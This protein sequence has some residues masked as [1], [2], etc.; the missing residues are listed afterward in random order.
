MDFIFTEGL[1][2]RSITKLALENEDDEDLEHTMDS[3][4]TPRLPEMPNVLHRELSRSMTNIGVRKFVID[5]PKDQELK[6]RERLWQFHRRNRGAMVRLKGLNPVLSKSTDKLDG[7]DTERKSDSDN[8]EEKSPREGKKVHKIRARLKMESRNSSGGHS[9]SVKKDSKESNKDNNAKYT[10]SSALT[11][12]NSIYSQLRG[13]E[14]ETMENIQRFPGPIECGKTKRSIVNSIDKLPDLSSALTK[15]GYMKLTRNVVHYGGGF[16]GRYQ[17]KRYSELGRSMSSIEGG[18]RPDTM[19]H[20]VA[21]YGSMNHL[22]TMVETSRVK[23]ETPRTLNKLDRGN[24]ENQVRKS[25][26]SRKLEDRR[27]KSK[28]SDS[29]KKP[30]SEQHGS[31]KATNSTVES[32]NNVTDFSQENQKT[33]RE[34]D[35]NG[36]EL[37]QETPSKRESN[38]MGEITREK[39]FRRES[40]KISELTQGNQECKGKDTKLEVNKVTRPSSDISLDIPKDKYGPS[41]QVRDVRSHRSPLMYGVNPYRWTN[42]SAITD[43][44]KSWVEH[45]MQNT[46]VIDHTA[47]DCFARTKPSNK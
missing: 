22:D 29:V 35:K 10:Y 40:F 1:R 46:D 13:K 32:D 4:T 38:K 11:I 18:P 31:S 15:L 44:D 47:Y 26:E 16:F 43:E 12:G 2:G 28:G 34:S 6:K 24:K 30:L 39:T 37:T 41:S 3:M 5:N 19:S 25:D 8:E 9:D 45:A 23:F 27:L 33:K 20:D 7:I 36:D 14:Q 42:K 17:E 21:V